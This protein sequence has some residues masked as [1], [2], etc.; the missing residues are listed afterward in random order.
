MA[1]N[2]T[3]AQAE[4]LANRLR[5]RFRHL[6]KWAK[7]SGTGAFRLYDRDIPEIPLTLDFYTGA[8][9]SPEAAL[10]GALYQRP[11]EKEEAEEERWLAAMRTA[12]SE[13]LSIDPQNIFLKR[14][15]RQTGA[16][17]YGKFG[18]R[19]VIRE[20]RE[21][22]LI[23][24][25]NLSDYLDTGLFLDRRLARNMIRRA[26]AGRRLLNLFCYTGSYSVYAADGGAVSTDSVDLS[27]TYLA[28]AGDNFSRNGF[29]AEPG[30]RGNF[31]ADTPGAAAH[32]LIRADAIAFLD[33]AAAAA[34]RWDLIILDP[35]AFSN[36]KKMAATLDLRRD[37]VKLICRC[38]ALLD[39]G[40][41][42][43]FSANV[44]HFGVKAEELEAALIP[45]FPDVRVM[46]LGN[47]TVDED[48]KGR[49]TPRDFVIKFTRRSTDL[50][51][52]PV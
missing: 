8:G 21:G 24:K 16:A 48:F 51:E 11:Y 35:P 42:L 38:L 49:K 25:I 14:R 46:D 10:T 2:R 7:R 34:R 28:W 44:R 9:N 40:G 29:T 41:S 17:Q 18:E 15:L 47:K 45:R 37:Y 39:A 33:H 30:Q 12:A 23:F 22:G 1:D 50:F 27:N 20:V 3:A 4:M 32:R 13:A 36:S 31:S 19:H 43:W 5:K 6:A 52:S 26:S